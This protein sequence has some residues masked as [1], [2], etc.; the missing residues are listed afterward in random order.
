MPL[1]IIIFVVAVV[2]A[3]LFEEMIFRGLF[4][5][6]IRSYFEAR[7]WSPTAQGPGHHRKVSCGEDRVTDRYGA[8][9][10]ILISSGLFAAVHTEPSH[11]PAMFVLGI[12]LGYAYEKSGS[13]FRPI[14]IHSFFN[15]TSIIA[16]LN[17]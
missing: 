14:F 13:L 5:T 10:A 9:V 11:W 8:W 1:R 3:S 12:G 4:Q 7:F 6:T 16:T 2:I 17:Q 15:A